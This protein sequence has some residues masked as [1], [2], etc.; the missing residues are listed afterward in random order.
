MSGTRV[1]VSDTMA[2]RL[3]DRYAKEGTNFRKP[4]EEFRRWWQLK[5]AKAWNVPVTGGTFKGRPWPGMKEQYTRKDGT[6]VPAWGGVPKVLGKGAVK[7]KKRPS[8]QRVTQSSKM[9]QDTNHL[10]RDFTLSV[11]EL[12][13]TRLRIGSELDYARE[14]HERR[15][16]AFWEKPTDTKML[17]GFCLAHLRTLKRR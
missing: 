14:Q 17:K 13:R 15:P 7:G 5:T 6:V 2:L 3:F 16:F 9:I 4:L 10:M 1:T 12:G 11:L 8:G